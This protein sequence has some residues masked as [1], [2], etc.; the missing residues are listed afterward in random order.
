MNFTINDGLGVISIGMADV[1]CYFK[2]YEPIA[3][4]WYSYEGT[5]SKY[6][7]QL[8]ISTKKKQELN[9]KIRVNVYQDYTHQLPELY[10]LLSPL[11]SL[12]EN[13]HYSLS[14]SSAEAKSFFHRGDGIQSSQ[15][16]I[17]RPDIY[18]QFT[19][20]KAHKTEKQASVV[21]KFTQSKENLISTPDLNHRA[22]SLGLGG[23]YPLK[24]LLIGTQSSEF[25]EAQ[26]V[27]QYKTEIK[28]GKRPFAIILRLDDDNDYESTN[29]VLDGH[30]KLQAY[31]DL[32][33]MPP[34]AVITITQK[35]PQT[36]KFDLEKVANLLHP[37]HTNHLL[38]HWGDHKDTLVKQTIQRPNSTLFKFIKQGLYEIYHNNGQ[39]RSRVFYL[40][41][42][43]DGLYEEWYD[44]G[45][46]RYRGT[47]KSGVPVD[48]CVYESWDESGNKTS[49]A[50]FKAGVTIKIIDFNVQRKESRYR[51]FDPYTGLLIKEFTRKL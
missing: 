26:V 3:V 21:H 44:N 40:N 16:V 42:E 38:Q 7:Y 29:Y 9:D 41:D 48:G 2:F 45:Q 32:N 8:P 39:L 36:F 18:W 5:I 37:L 33:I 11:F 17:A 30:H 13:G 22:Y 46:M 14:F 27:E 19:Q 10:K 24:N 47:Y 50:Y 43:K 28:A 4:D 12:F 35:L 6:S 31:S 23:Y 1:G 49:E 25:I 34:L 15:E 20:R 51:I